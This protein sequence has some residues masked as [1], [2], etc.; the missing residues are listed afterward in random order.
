MGLS[1]QPHK[2]RPAGLPSAA[3]P[4]CSLL[5]L[6]LCRDHILPC[7]FLL[8]FDGDEGSA[9]D[10]F[11]YFDRNGDGSISCSE[12]QVCGCCRKQLGHRTWDVGCRQ[13]QHHF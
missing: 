2:L 3:V 4:T 6:L 11:A 8:F 9:H 1:H 13:Q 12:L 7:D 5:I 10:A